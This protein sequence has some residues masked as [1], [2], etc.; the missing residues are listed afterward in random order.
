MCAPEI[1][2]VYSHTQLRE[3]TVLY[4]IYSVK[5]TPSSKT[6]KDS[7]GQEIVCILWN[8]RVHYHVH[9]SLSFESLMASW[10]INAIG[11]PLRKVSSFLWLVKDHLTLNIPGVYSIPFECEPV[12]SITVWTSTKTR[13]K[14][15]HQHICHN[16]PEKLAAVEHITKP[17]PFHPVTDHLY[18]GQKI[19]IR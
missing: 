8:P 4:L 2:V 1:S 3:S 15:H 5:Q 10:N 9:N 18:L 17:V 19:E 7:V 14:D 13:V 11:L 16:H 12:Y 6:N